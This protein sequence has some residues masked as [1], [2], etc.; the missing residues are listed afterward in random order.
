LRRMVKEDN[1]DIGEINGLEETQNSTGTFFSKVK[2]KCIQPEEMLYQIVNGMTIPAFVIDK[3]HRVIYWNTACENLTGIKSDEIIGTDRQWMA[4]Y[5]E[6]RP[7][8]ADLIVDGQSDEVIEKYYGE[9]YQK[10]DLIEGAYEAEAFFPS[11]GEKGMWLFFTAAPLKNSDG[12]VIGAI[13]TLQDIT[14]RKNLEKSLL[15]VNEILKII[16]KILSHDVLNDLTIVSG[17][18]EVFRENRDEKLL[19]IAL[20]SIEKSVK[21]IR[22]MK[23]LESLASSGNNLKPCDMRRL[24][25]EIMEWYTIEHAIEGEAIV[26]ADEALTSVIENIIRNAIV[27]GEASR[28]DFKVIDRED[29]SILRIADNGK[30]IPKEVKS[31]IFKEGFSHGKTKGT[32]LGLYIARKTIERYNGE[33]WIEDNHPRG[34]VFVLK[35]TKPQTPLLESR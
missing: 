2:Q 3:H 26:Q 9:I 32:G 21:L 31:K 11:L 35:L 34:A 28:L 4:F 22:E 30:G 5:P 12:E 20:N 29:F 7:V 27:H 25:E 6:E 18:I 8:M 1:S 17:S 19:N 15:H 10:S 16:N 24:V 23:D 33:I 14:V 13:E